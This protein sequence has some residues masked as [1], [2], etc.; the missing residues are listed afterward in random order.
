[1]SS[2]DEKP[3]GATSAP[4]M[5]AKRDST[6]SFCLRARAFHSSHLAKEADVTEPGAAAAVRLETL[7]SRDVAGPSQ[8]ETIHCI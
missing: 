1:M 7:Q 5:R 6:S 3:Q 2:R 8:E 4:T